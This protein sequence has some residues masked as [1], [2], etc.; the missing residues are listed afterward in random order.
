MSEQAWFPRPLGRSIVGMDPVAQ[1]IAFVPGG[2]VPNE[3]QHSFA[4][5]ASDRQQ[6]D[7]EPPRLYAVGLSL[8]ETEQDGVVV[9]PH[10]T[11]TSQG[12]VA[13]GAA[14]FALHKLQFF[15]WRGPGMGLGLGKTGKPAFILVHQQPVFMLPGLLFQPVPP[16][17]FTVYNRS[18]L[19]MRCLAR[20]QSMPITASVAR[21][22]SPLTRVPLSPKSTHASASKSSVHKLVS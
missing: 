2:V 13:L 18:G 4:F 7:D 21:M 5:L 12:F 11:K 22:V 15:P 3:D 17:F 19:V 16:F 10:S 8:T 6:T 20:R 1:I 14:R 9:V